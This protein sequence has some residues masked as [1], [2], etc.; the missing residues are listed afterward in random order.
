M[1]IIH[2]SKSQWSLTLH[3]VVKLNGEWHRY[4]NYRCVTVIKFLRLIVISF[5]ILQDFTALLASMWVLSRVDLI[6][7]YY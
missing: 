3:L 4:G 1:E 7:G 2:P 6:G 5:L